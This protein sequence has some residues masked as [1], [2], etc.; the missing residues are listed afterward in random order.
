M[1]VVTVPFNMADAMKIFIVSLPH[2]HNTVNWQGSCTFSTVESKMPAFATRCS[3]VDSEG[4]SP[5]NMEG[6]IGEVFGENTVLCKNNKKEIEMKKKANLF[7]ELP[8]S[9]QLTGSSK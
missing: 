8:N 4:T 7:K 9:F 5:V 1:D 3:L 6:R 2:V